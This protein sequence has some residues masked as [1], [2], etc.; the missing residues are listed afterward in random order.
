MVLEPEFQLLE[1]SMRQLH[2]VAWQISCVSEID[3]EEVI[4]KAAFTLSRELNQKAATKTFKKTSR[5]LIPDILEKGCAAHLVQHLIDMPE[6]N[7]VFKN[8]NKHFD[9]SASQ[10]EALQLKDKTEIK[11][12]VYSGAQRNFSY[13]YKNYPAFDLVQSGGFSELLTEF[14]GFI[15]SKPFLKVISNI[16]G[17]E[18]IKFTDAQA[19]RYEPGHFL[20]SH[21]DMVAGKNRLAAFVFNLSADWHPDWGG[22]LLFYDDSQNF[23]NVFA[24]K[25]NSLSLFSVGTKHAVSLISPFA[26]APRLAVTGWFRF[27]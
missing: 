1:A 20:T 19:T 22:N 24:P 9:L 21:N 11:N 27:R 5:I 26:R 25:M 7:L 16:S 8:Q 23:R 14:L 2:K 6:W 10:F 4:N 3:G 12:S 18:N 17:I 13:M 15:N